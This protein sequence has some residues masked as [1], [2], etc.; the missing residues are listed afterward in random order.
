MDFF[1]HTRCE[2]TAMRHVS[3]RPYA[4]R[5]ER[6]RQPETPNQR[7]ILARKPFGQMPFYHP[8]N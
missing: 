7:L 4:L 2:A 6:E 1:S 5:E 3:H 8:S